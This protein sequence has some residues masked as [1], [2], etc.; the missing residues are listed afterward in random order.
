MKTRKVSL[1]VELTTDVPIKK[2]KEDA[3]MALENLFVE[4]GFALSV[5]SISANVYQL[6]KAGEA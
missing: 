2:L 6:V 1:S 4:T 3:R 5:D